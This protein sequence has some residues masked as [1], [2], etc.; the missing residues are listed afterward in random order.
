METPDKESFP[1]I[2]KF[3]EIDCVILKAEQ[4]IYASFRRECG[5]ELFWSGT[6]VPLNS[7]EPENSSLL[8]YKTSTRK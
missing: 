1:C 6:K 7:R 2:A 8:G 3:C 5:F 4:K